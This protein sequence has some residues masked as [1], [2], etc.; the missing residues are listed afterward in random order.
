MALLFATG[1]LL[2]VVSSPAWAREPAPVI[3]GTA[4]SASGSSDIESRLLKIERRLD[5]QTLSDILKRL[6]RLQQEIQRIAGDME[7]QAHNV[8]GMQK[9]QREL[10]LDIDRRLGTMEKMIDQVQDAQQAQGSPTG[11]IATMPFTPAASPPVTSAAAPKAG[12]VTTITTPSQ[13]GRGLEREAYQRAFNLLKEGRYKLA[14]AS[15]QAFI[16]TYPNVSYT[17]NAQYWLGEANYV[18]KNYKE[19]LVEFQKVVD[20]YPDSKKIPDAILKMGYTYEQMG[21]K[22]KA[23]SMLESVIKK[24]SGSTAA[25]LANRRLQD[26]KRSQ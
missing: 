6:D 18:Q 23:Q 13:A 21:D 2:S 25:Q 11:A 15:F 12:S 9:R 17:A 19:A 7:V 1:S 26:I 5:N 16:E 14:I 24:F 8:D 10:Y 4:G 3:E 22:A 20:K